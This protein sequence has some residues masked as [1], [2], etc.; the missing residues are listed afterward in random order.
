M[1]K[2]E[3]IMGVPLKL[4]VI[5]KFIINLGINLILVNLLMFVMNLDVIAITLKQILLTF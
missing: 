3:E 4:L 2:K 5:N 1:T